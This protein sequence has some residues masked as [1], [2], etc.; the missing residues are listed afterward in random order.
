MP[1]GVNKKVVQLVVRAIRK[2]FVI[3]SNHLYIRDDYR[4][5]QKLEELAM[6]RIFVIKRKTKCKPMNRDAS[7]SEGASS[8]AEDSGKTMRATKSK[9]EN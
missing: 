4:K 1:V 7:E 2:L 9:K 6:E 8:D 5:L 3:N